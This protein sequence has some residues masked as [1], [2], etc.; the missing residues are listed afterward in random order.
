[1]S[2]ISSIVAYIVPLAVAGVPPMHP[3]SH[4]ARSTLRQRCM[5]PRSAALVL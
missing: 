3:I 4:Q 5:R 2:A 1:M